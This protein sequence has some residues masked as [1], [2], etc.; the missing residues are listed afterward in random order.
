LPHEALLYLDHEEFLDASLRFIGEAI[1][2]D[3][4]VL[5]ALAGEKNSEIRS[6]LGRRSGAVLFADLS[7]LGGNP[8]RIMPVWEDFLN[9]HRARGD[10]LRG[11][12]EPFVPGQNPAELPSVSA[13]K[14]C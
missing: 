7:E 1:A 12:G 9:E 2:K 5:V 8:A 13:T 10:R 11:I 3:D 14:R 4:P 6:R